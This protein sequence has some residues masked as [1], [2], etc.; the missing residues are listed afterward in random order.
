MWPLFFAARG[1]EKPS[2]RSVAIV[3]PSYFRCNR[4]AGRPAAATP[5]VLLFVPWPLLS[6]ISCHVLL[7]VVER[8]AVV[9]GETRFG[10]TYLCLK[11]NKPTDLGNKQRPPITNCTLKYDCV[12]GVQE[13]KKLSLKVEVPPARKME[14]IAATRQGNS[15]PRAPWTTSRWP[16]SRSAKP[17]RPRLRS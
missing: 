13:H 3:L 6:P 2:G 1:P 9:S 16:R 8:C 4:W 12:A 17:A 14:S 5:S 11:S 15:R 7:S 10:H